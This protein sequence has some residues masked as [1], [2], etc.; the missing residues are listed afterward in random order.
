M[1]S[2]QSDRRQTTTLAGL[3]LLC[4]MVFFIPFASQ[5]QVHPGRFTEFSD[6]LSDSSK[7]GALARLQTAFCFDHALGPINP[8]IE[9]TEEEEL[10]EY[11][12]RDQALVFKFGECLDIYRW[13]EYMHCS[14]RAFQELSANERNDI[15]FNPR[16][17]QWEEE[18]ALRGL[19]PVG[20]MHS[21]LILF[22]RC[23]HD[24][25]NS[26]QEQ[27]DLTIPGLVQKRTV[28][29]SGIALSE[30][31]DPGAFFDRQSAWDASVEL[32]A[33]YYSNHHDYRYPEVTFGYSW[34]Q[35]RAA[36]MGTAS[37]SYDLSSNW[38]LAA[39]LHASELFFAS[40]PNRPSAQ[41]MFSR[42]E[43]QLWM[44]GKAANVALCLMNERMFDEIVRISADATNTLCIGLR[45]CPN[46]NR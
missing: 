11:P 21:A 13:N 24:V 9:E 34:E 3:V 22:H 36:L 25:D 2:A 46:G 33:E 4:L 45:V 39:R 1:K 23:K 41:G 6:E 16:A 38:T 44:K 15:H 40:A 26:D 7:F 19:F 12:N 31:T 14:F 29:L 27:Q 10:S 32:R 35:A 8:D 37:L 20:S 17:V 18:L 43:L 30:S 42:F 28:I 5:A